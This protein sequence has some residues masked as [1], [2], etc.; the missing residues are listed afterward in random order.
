[1]S[2]AEDLE[3]FAAW[4]GGDGEAGERLLARHRA[5][6]TRF[7]QSRCPDAPDDL[8]QATFLAALEA[9]DRYRGDAPFVTFLLGIAHR[10][11]LDHVRARAND[12]R[13]HHHPSVDFVRDLSPGAQT[14]MSRRELEVALLDALV[15]L[16][17]ELALVIELHYWERLTREQI[18][19]LLALPAGTV[20]SRLRRA[21]E[22][23]LDRLEQ[24][25]PPGELATGVRPTLEAWAE[26]TRESLFGDPA[27][28]N[29]AAGA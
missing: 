5:A 23:L 6:L 2:T 3:L 1:V 19:A 18:A 9:R 12:A 21:R 25:S 8:I 24:A 14:L 16:P 11:V 4:R 10:K 29:S 7:V 20:A 17:P 27:A 15:D 26:G 28:T 22:Q 13:R